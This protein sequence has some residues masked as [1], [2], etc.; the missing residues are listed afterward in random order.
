MEI[1]QHIISFILFNRSEMFRNPF[2]PLAFLFV[3]VLPC[4]AGIH[5]QSTIK[6]FS[7]QSLKIS[8]D[9]LIRNNSGNK[10]AYAVFD[11]DNTSVYGD[12]QETLLIYQLENLIFK[13]TP[14]EFEYS[15][16]HYA[17]TGHAENLEIPSADFDKAYTNADGKPLNIGLMKDDCVNYYKFFFN[18]YRKLNPGAGGNFTLAQLKQTAQYKDFLAKMWFTYAAIY[19]SF[20]A[21]A[22]YTWVMYVTVPGFT[23]D[24]FRTMVTE[25][26][27]GGIR[28]ESKK[29]YFDS[30]LN[31]KSSAGAVSNT[32]AG[33]Y[34]C[35]IIRMCPEMGS[36]FKNL[37]KNSIP[38]YIS[39][40]SFQEI[41]DAVAANPK[42]GYSI[43]PNRVYGLRL[44]TDDEG[45]YLPQYDFSE[46][47]TINSMSG[48]T[49][50]INNTLVEKYKAN[51][52]MIGGDSDGDYYMITELTGLDGMKMA[53]NYKP[54]Q[55]IMVINRVKGGDIGKICRIAA[56]QLEHEKT[57]DV[58][59]VLQ[60]RDENK[61]VWVPSE[62][63]LK[64]GE[65][66]ENKFRLLP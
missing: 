10:N 45:R 36:I 65:F 33:N 48:K 27:D 5:A 1:I 43:P 63:T 44:K 52:V 29:V 64:L 61:G 6:G 15:F 54:V 19:K 20:S 35:N 55:L 25:A 56:G 37:E 47:Y 39:T 50:N 28:R 18:N 23:K 12:V 57:G 11:W 4:F 60:G 31:I 2:F 66:G 24:E 42:Y 8:F 16:T 13:M 3:L 46:N 59:V 30:P 9:E 41:V 7:S 17:E 32:E 38:V 40:A 51:P 34:F 62:K 26:I 58:S 49:I 21:N 22:A 14:G 53:N